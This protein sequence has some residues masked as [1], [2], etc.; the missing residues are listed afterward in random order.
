MTRAARTGKRFSGKGA[1]SAGSHRWLAL[2]AVPTCLVSMGAMAQVY[3]DP[4]PVT[5]EPVQNGTVQDGTVQDAAPS[6]GMQGHDAMGTGQDP[7]RQELGATQGPLAPAADDDGLHIRAGL[8]AGGAPRY[9]G[10]DEYAGNLAPIIDMSYG[11]YFFNTFEGLGAR[12]QSDG[13][14]SASASLFIDG[15]RTSKQDGNYLTGA[16][17]KLKGMNNVKSSGILILQ[18]TLPVAEWLAISARADTRITGQRHRGTSYSLSLDSSVYQTERDDV[19][20]SIAVNGGDRDYNNTY[21][22]VTPEESLTSRF[23]AF[24]AKAGLHSASVSA[25][26][27]HVLDEKWALFSQVNVDQLGGKVKDSPLVEKKTQATAAVGFTYTF[28]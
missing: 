8:A 24:K 10:S 2:L 6:D 16:S 22:G 14:A 19:G 11:P 15:G 3:S 4:P 13:G 9:T 18:G 28:R 12:L 20:L 17:K 23:S 26:W 27:T 5:P 25:N 7:Q 21:F 1:R